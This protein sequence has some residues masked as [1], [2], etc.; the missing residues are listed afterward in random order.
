MPGIKKT[1]TFLIQGCGPKEKRI[2]VKNYFSLLAASKDDN[3]DSMNFCP[4]IV[5]K[6]DP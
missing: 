1:A 5:N 4:L 2:C 3:T 6:N